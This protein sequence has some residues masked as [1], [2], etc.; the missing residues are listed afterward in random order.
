MI[1]TIIVDDEI[2]SR[3]GI[4]SLIDGK[5]EV[6]VCG[7]FGSAEEALKFLEDVFV[8]IVITDI[9]MLDMNGLEFIE[10]IREKNLAEG[11]IILSCHEKFSYAQEAISKGTD[12]YLLKH[13]VTEESLMQE[14]KKAY[15]KNQTRNRK[16]TAAVADLKKEGEL[17][18]NGSYVL[19]VLRAG[20]GESGTEELEM[21]LESTMLAHLLEEIVD[22]HGMGTLFSPYNKEM[23]IVFQMD[24]AQNQEALDAVSMHFYEKDVRVFWYTEI[25]EEMEPVSFCPD[26]LL[27]EGGLAKFETQLSLAL[28]KGRFERVKA[29]VLKEQ[30]MQSLNMFIHQVLAGYS[31]REDF[32]RKWNGATTLVSAITAAQNAEMLKASIL[33]VVGCFRTELIEE[34]EKDDLAEA[35]RYI[36]KNLPNRI[37]LADLTEISCMSVPSFSKKFKERTGQSLVQYLNDKRIERA[38]SLL[39]NK[40]YSL[41][42]VAELTGFSNANYLIRVFK[43][44]TGKTVGE[45]RKRYGIDEME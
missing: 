12:S 45:Y 9:E 32:S 2:L 11:I 41:E 18:E 20:T 29:D 25:S 26:E 7:T 14:I 21:H 24:A 13:N 8:D 19:A 39:K 5:E 27:E 31:F 17:L 36:E 23:F 42:Q 30:L 40:N 10:V 6:T 1:R 3:I 38:C 37:T 4:Q 34:W 15:Q 22:R 16:H 28:A 44:R 33:K 35:F 43:K